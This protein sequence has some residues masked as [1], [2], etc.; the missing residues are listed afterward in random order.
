[1]NWKQ[2]IPAGLALLFA[3]LALPAQAAPPW[4]ATV[5][6]VSDGDTL[7]VQRSGQAAPI[8]LRLDGIDAPELCQRWGLAARDL[9]SARVLH[10]PVQVHARA[11]DAY[12]RVLARIEWRGEDVGAWMVAH[13]AAWSYRYRR[14]GG[15]YQAL[16]AQ[17]R[18][19][20]RGLF[21]E[22]GAE[23]P[24]NFRRRHGPCAGAGTIPV[25]P[26]ALNTIPRH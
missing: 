17:A 15:P 24:R 19:A 8:K 26:R 2:L 23:P 16:E 1:M 20:G 25:P 21:A 3:L 13:G 18:Q 9:L 5:T 12:G 22:P 6:H 11:S 10:Q 4:M 7:W 14:S